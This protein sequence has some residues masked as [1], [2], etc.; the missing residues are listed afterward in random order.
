MMK[1]G[2]KA[3]KKRKR[4]AIARRR[5]SYQKYGR[6]NSDYGDFKVYESLVGEEIQVRSLAEWLIL[7]AL[8]KKRAAIG[9]TIA[10]LSMRVDLLVADVR[11]VV[12]RMIAKNDL[13]ERVY[14][15]GQ[16]VIRIRLTKEGYVLMRE[17]VRR[18]HYLMDKG[19]MFGYEPEIV[20]LYEFL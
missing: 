20:P 15:S 1:T 8:L 2:L 18:M 16:L 9:L 4:T 11:R 12:L 7:I 3:Y 17:Q 13:V 19:T 14:V 5:R 6:K 10:D